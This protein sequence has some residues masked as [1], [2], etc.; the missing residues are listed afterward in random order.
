MKEHPIIFNPEMVR[1]IMDGRKSQTRRLM[2]VKPKEHNHGQYEGAHWQHAK[3]EY[4]DSGD[5]GRICQYCGEGM[6]FNGKSV[7]RSPYGAAGDQLWVRETWWQAGNSVLVPPYEDE[8]QWSRSRRILY[9][10][11]GDPPPM[12]QTEIILTVCSMVHSR[13]RSQTRFGK[14]R[15]SIHMP[16]WASR[17]TLNV[18]GVRIERLYDIT[19]HDALLEGVDLAVVASYERAGV[20]RPA[21]FAFRDLWIST[22]GEWESNPWVWVYD[23][24]VAKNEQQKAA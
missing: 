14:K 6:D 23:F 2:R 5:N 24:E 9:A 7:Y 13:R 8:Y 22:G 12:S 17:T 1:A 19:E 15:P 16:R 10:V 4:Y 18:L 3:P 11:D 21:A 20:D